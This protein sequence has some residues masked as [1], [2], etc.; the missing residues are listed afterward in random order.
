MTGDDE[1]ETGPEYFPGPPLPAGGRAVGAAVETGPAGSARPDA[2]Q[3]PDAGLA[4]LTLAALTLVASARRVLARG[5][6]D[7][8]LRSTRAPPD[9]GG[10][11]GKNSRSSSPRPWS[12]PC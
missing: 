1:P 3:A 2:P 8:R 4:A 12:S 10:R 11:C 5:P 7:L 9:A 6:L